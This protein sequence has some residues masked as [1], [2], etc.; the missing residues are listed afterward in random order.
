M[1]R[2]RLG[3][4]YVVGVVAR[5]WEGKDECWALWVAIPKA[6]MESKGPGAV[7]PLLTWSMG[8]GLPSSM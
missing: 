8:F 5:L 6:L 2:L 3:A 4:C 1:C 7:E